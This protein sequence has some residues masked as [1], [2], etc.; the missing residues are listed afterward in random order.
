MIL[1]ENTKTIKKIKSR[2]S[3][4]ENKLKIKLKIAGKNITIKGEEIAKYEATNV[5]QA[6][7]KGFPIEEALLLLNENYIFELMNIKNLA[8][9]KD[10]SQIR[11]RIIGRKGK[12]L[13]VLQELTECYLILKD[14]YVYIIGP[15]EKIKD[16]LNGIRKLIQ[17]SKQSSTYTYL[18]RQRK[19]EVPSDLG[20]K[21]SK[22]KDFDS[23]QKSN[24]KKISDIKK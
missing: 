7:D 17:G 11:A 13:K 5:F 10:I 16:C 21:T 8:T 19:V 4:L 23:A 3:F 15:S 2:K 14:N 12:T 20:L 24:S 6:I 9:R 18:E 22:S 1:I